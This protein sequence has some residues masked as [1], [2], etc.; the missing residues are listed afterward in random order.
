MNTLQELI[1]VH[2]NNRNYSNSTAYR[3]VK[4]NIQDR[5]NKQSEK[6]IMTTTYRGIK[7]QTQVEVVK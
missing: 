1:Q 6:K 7:T 2:N 5:A 4:Y 3:G